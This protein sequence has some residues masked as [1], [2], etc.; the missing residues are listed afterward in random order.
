MPKVSDYCIGSDVWPG[1]SKLIEEA[2]EVQL[3]CVRTISGRI[4]RDPPNQYPDPNQDRI[5][6]QIADAWALID[7]TP[8]YAIYSRRIPSS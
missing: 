8:L 4:L 1:L 3:T 5:A 2:G 6:S 7:R